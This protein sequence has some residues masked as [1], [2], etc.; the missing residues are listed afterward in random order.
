M[1]NMVFVPKGCFADDS[2]A[3]AK[4]EALRQKLLKGG[5]VVI[6]KDGNAMGKGGDDS[7]ISIPKGKLASQWYENNPTLLEMEK[8]VMQKA[9]P[10]FELGKLDDGRLYWVGKLNLGI[11]ESKFNEPLEYHIMALYQNNH[12]NQQ[13]GSSVRVY[14][15]IPDVQELIDKCGFRPHHLL[16]D[17]DNQ[18]YLCTNYAEDQKVGDEITTA[19]SVLGWACKW[20][21]AY[22]LV[23]TGDLTREQFDGKI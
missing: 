22:E 18:I 13:M 17:S 10:D 7:T 1:G 3:K 5:K 15:I 19:A 11:Y 21:S 16:K 23:M 9:F 2:E 14:P 6:K 4:R 12:P 20:F 8:I